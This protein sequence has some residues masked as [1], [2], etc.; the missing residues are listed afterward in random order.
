MHDNGLLKY[1]RTKCYKDGFIDARDIKLQEDLTASMTATA[2]RCKSPVG[3]FYKKMN[4][5]FSKEVADAEI[6]L[7]QLYQTAGLDSA[8]YLPGRDGW[9]T[10]LLS[11]DVCGKDVIEARSFH[12]RIADKEG[13]STP[14]MATLTSKPYQ[15]GSDIVKYFTKKALAKRI[16]TRAYDS[17]GHN[18]DR[19]DCN[20]VYKLN[21]LGQAEDLA[22]FD[23]ERGGIEASQ[24]MTFGRDV[25]LGYGYANDQGDKNISR[26]GMI[27]RLKHDEF[28]ASVVDL[29]QVGEQMGN[30]DVKGTALDIARTTGYVVEPRYVDFISKSFNQT[31]ELLIK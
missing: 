21:D 11:N 15:T 12:D 3:Y 14:V 30:I 26:I 28:V 31:A 25:L 20:Y 24:C 19:Q 16:I 6:L 9:K 2:I 10:F 13:I 18:P 1:Y 29:S 23:Y 7:S 22:L 27:D 8:I 4:G 5:F 17:A